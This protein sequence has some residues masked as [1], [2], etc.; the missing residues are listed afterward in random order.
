METSAS[1]SPSPISTRPIPYSRTNPETSSNMR[2]SF[3]GNPFSRPSVLSNHRGFTPVTPANSPAD[4]ARRH[5]IGK[6]NGGSSRGNEEKENEK[7]QNQNIKPVKVRSPAISKGTKSFMAPTISAASKIN[8]SPRKKILAER[9]EPARSSSTSFSDGKS[10]FGSIDFS[11]IIEEIDSKSEMGLN[12]NGVENSSDSVIT[13]S[14]P[15]VLELPLV[16]KASKKDKFLNSQVPLN[17]ENSSESLLD[18]KPVESNCTSVSIG[19]KTKPLDSSISPTIAP[20]DADPSLPPYDPKTNYLSPR[21]QFLHYRPNPRI[22]VY[23]H[24]EKGK[25]LEDC[26]LTESF[27]D[28]EVSEEIESRDSNK[29]SEDDSSVEFINKEEEEEE[30]HRSEPKPSSVPSMETDEEE[31]PRDFEP[32]PIKTDEEKK[33]VL[34]P[35]FFPKS[36]SIALLLVLL[37]ACLSVS[38]ID[39]P[40]FDLPAYKEINISKFSNQSEIAEFV[41]ASYDGFA[42]NLNKWSENCVCYL[43]KLIGILDEVDKLGPLK[44]SNLTLLLGDRFIDGFELGHSKERSEETHK[45]NDKFEPLAAS[46]VEITPFEEQLEKVDD[47]NVE[48][49]N[50]KSEETELEG[51]VIEEA[52]LTLEA[53]VIEHN[54]S[55]EVEQN[56]EQ[57]NIG[58]EDHSSLTFK[59][60]EFNPELVE[61]GKIQGDIGISLSDH[62]ESTIAVDN[63][64]KNYLERDVPFGEVQSSEALNSSLNQSEGKF[65]AHYI[66]TLSL[67]A[68]AAAMAAF[69][70]LKHWRTSIPH[71]A[72]FLFDPLSSEKMNLIPESASTR[73][74]WPAEVD[75]VGESCPSEMSSFQK[76]SSYSKKGELRGSNETQSRER[77]QRKTS[78]RESLASSSDYSMMGSPSYGSFTTYEKISNKL[79]FGEEETV[80]PVRRSSRIKHQVTLS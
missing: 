50:D 48:E 64:R 31:E 20:L 40:A 13:D 7:D 60:P 23:L 36:K 24:K 22:E 2:R 43:S 73:Q 29:E 59:D 49:A 61:T 21:P 65:S 63:P 78:K 44:F 6:E 39:S 42:R 56:Q 30:P 46:K 76:S 54:N 57:S 52:H 37:I 27:S 70:Y 19:C 14:D 32:K 80:T 67:L 58:Y 47:P 12:Q 41:R 79:G 51:H 15:K 75:V 55:S 10:S 71:C 33:A 11:N 1:R 28:N 38:V 8:A 77:K 74:I 53:E 68:L 3:S 9:N 66:W 16:S 69:V 17:L 35:Q 5:S 62:I 34:K 25:R 26:F 72:P 45:K 4:L 18:L